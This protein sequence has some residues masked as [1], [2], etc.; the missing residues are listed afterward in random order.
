[1]LPQLVKIGIVLAVG[2]AIFVASFALT[3]LTYG[4]PFE[5]HIEPILTAMVAGFYITNYTD[6][7]EQFEHLLHDISPAIYVAFFT[8]TGVG[9]K[10][11]ILSQTWPIA[12]ALFALRVF[13]IGIGSY[14][15]S[16][17]AGESNTFAFN[18]GL[19]LITQA[20]I[21]L[22]LARE[23]A[24]EFPELGDAFSTMVISV[25][26][27]NEIFGPM[28]LKRSLKQVGDSEITTSAQRATQRDVVIFGIEQ[29]SIALARQLQD[30]HW[31][32]ILADTDQGH[33]YS[34]G[35]DEEI[36][37][38]EYHVPSLE[39]EELCK[40]ITKE[41]DAVVAMLA[42]DEANISILEI[43]YNMGVPRLVVRPVDLSHAERYREMNALVIEPTSAMVHLLEQ[44]ILAPQPSAILLRQDSG[45][46]LRQV[47]VSNPDVAGRLIRD[48]SLPNDVLFLDVTRN[49]Q[50]LLPNGY[51]KLRLWDE[52]TIVGR[53]DNLDEAVFRLGY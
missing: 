30:D 34:L 42:D 52:V 12:L 7:R 6:A 10:L 46:E 5:L 14:F 36:D 25:I 26:V 17:S 45:R 50:V 38:A 18:S 1:P 53:G 20:G 48:L 33:V 29:Q 40:L 51:T 9:I 41:T 37:L 27:L 32:V 16:R 24:I 11:D 2:Y 13:G 4:T 43:A 39:K 15:G 31:N 44:T 28:L 21:A 35:K 49:G 19:G 22:G 8:L 47:T 23:V 3:D